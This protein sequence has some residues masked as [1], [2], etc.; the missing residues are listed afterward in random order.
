MKKLLVFL[1]AAVAASATLPAFA[2]TI[3]LS[4]LSG[5]VV[6]RNGDVLTGELTSDNRIY[7]ADGA[8][9]T[10]SNAIV[11]NKAYLGIV[12]AGIRC[13][14]DA[15]IVL[16]GCNAVGGIRKNPGIFVPTNKT[17]TIT[18]SGSLTACGYG[19]GAGIGGGPGNDCGNIIIKGGVINAIGGEMAA[20]I[21]GA[22]SC[23]CGNITIIGGTVA[24]SGAANA[25]GIGAGISG[26]CG[27][28]TISGGTVTA[29]G[30]KMAAG[31]GS[32]SDVD[33]SCGDININGG[34]VVA[35]CGRDCTNPIGAGYYASCGSVTVADGL[36]ESRGSRT[37]VVT[38]YGTVD[39]SMCPVKDRDDVTFC[40]GI[41]LTGTLAVNGKVSIADGAT[42]TLRD[43][44]INGEDSD[45]SGWAGIACEGDATIILEGSNSVRGFGSGFPGIYVPTN[46]TLTIKGDGALTASSYGAAGIGYG[47]FN[48][49]GSICIDGGTIV[50]T[51]GRFYPGIGGRTS[52]CGT[53]AIGSGVTRVVATAGN[54]SQFP[55]AGGGADPNVGVT[56]ADGLLD[57]TDGQTRTIVSGRLDGLTED[58]TLADGMVAT[59]TLHGNR[60]VSIADGATVTLRNVM[61]VGGDYP[62]CRWAG[63]TCEGDATIVIEG[64]S[65]V[66]AFYQDY[67][68][69]S[70]P[71][72][73]TLTIKGAG[74]LTAVGGGRGAGIGGGYGMDCGDIDIWSGSI[75]ALG[76]QYA[77]GI[78][79]GGYGSCGS[80]VARMT[81][82]S[83]MA[84]CG[85]DCSN[86]IGCGA[87]GTGGSVTVEFPLS[88]AS[89]ATTR[90]ISSRIVDLSALT[91]DKRVFDGFYIFG[92][93]A[94][95]HKVSIAD[96]ATVTLVGVE[97]NGV[98]D[99]GCQWAGITCEGDATIIL[100]GP[101]TVK[102]FHRNYPGIYVP[103]GKT[104][105]I[106]GEGVLNASSNG[107]GAGIGGGFYISC[108]NIT[109]DG[110]TVNAAG[111]GY[112]AGI[113]GGSNGGCGTVSIGSGA[114]CV[115]AKCGPSCGNPLGAGASGT[116]GSVRIDHGMSDSTAGDTRT[117]RSGD[118]SILSWYATF[119]DGTVLTGTLDAGY[120]V[121]IAAGATVTLSNA[122]ING[123]N[124]G[125]RQW[126]GITCE[127]DAT[128]VLQGKNTITGFFE[129]YPGI[130]VPSG[131]TL[132]IRGDGVLNASGNGFGAGI[133]GGRGIE[134]GNIVIED[135]RI[136]ATGGAGAAG[137]GGGMG[138]GCGDVS[139]APD[140]SRVVAT[141]GDGCQNPIGAGEGGTCDSVDVSP[142]MLRDETIGSTR[143]LEGGRIIYLDR[144]TRDVA[145]GKN[146]IVKDGRILTG[147]LHG[148]YKISIWEGATV[149]LRDAIIERLGGDELAWAGITCRGNATIVLEGDNYVAGFGEDYPGIYVPPRKTLTIRGDGSL[150]ATT[151]EDGYGAGI[152]AST[153]DRCGNI[154]IEGGT[155]TAKGGYFA[156]GIGGT[157]Q[158]CGI[159][160]INGGNITATGGEGAAGIGGGLGGVCRGVN[161]GS[162]IDRVVATAGYALLESSPNPNPSP[163]GTGAGEMALCGG[164]KLAFGL[165]REDSTDDQERST[166]TIEPSNVDLSQLSGTG[167][168]ILNDGDIATGKLA[169]G[170]KVCIAAG[171]TVMLS[172]VDINFE[173]NEGSDT[174][175]A[176]ITCL[177]NA[178]IMIAGEN[179]V[180]GCCSG[181]PG[182]YVPEDA[183]LTVSGDDGLLYAGGCNYGAGIGGGEGSIYAKCGSVVV[184]GGNVM[185]VG[186][187]LA[188]GL[189]SGHNA[190]CGDITISGGFVS[191]TGGTGGAGIGTGENGQCGAITISGRMI[192]AEGGQGA[193][194]IGSGHG[195]TCGAISI[196]AD[197]TYVIAASGKDCTN[198]IGAGLNGSCA[199]VTVAK[200]LKDELSEDRDVRMISPKEPSA[201]YSSWADVNG[202][203]G[204][205]D[206]TDANGIH[207]VFRYA[208]DKPTGV[209]TIIGIEFND[210]GKAVVVTPPLVNGEGFSL[211]ILA[212]DRCDGEGA[213]ATSYPLDPS[214][215]T[216]I[217][218]TVSGS[219]FFR[220]KAQEE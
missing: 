96:G 216:T 158:G 94:G 86:P 116:G 69:I 183:T 162:G 41:A 85:A 174:P 51:G 201:G 194:G 142:D 37:R 211:S 163:I 195:G 102:G 148:D 49:C 167:T 27:D 28:I 21:G 207:N 58:I 164:V 57:S 136:T 176:G 65:Y 169:A 56:V 185:A 209:F 110:G 218:E 133:G 13:Y 78:G 44:T 156:A 109:I 90:C 212:T 100:D 213:A 38:A 118:L 202:I 74:S 14:G 121:S 84:T 89:N 177:G 67:P 190:V 93:L 99:S 160:T 4:T 8:V 12:S 97:I 81:I 46:K 178:V 10:L 196:T 104:L 72:G 52:A 157:G 139:V 125:Y 48:P 73:K 147:Q 59:G 134:C 188:A 68:G 50:A 155:I 159:I 181:Y 210:A 105:R 187:D 32:G 217:D 33:S 40:D 206:A 91:E 61:I 18:G 151:G 145:I 42:V 120:K 193:A 198:P 45:Y 119:A 7:I 31:I 9:V 152:G 26:S 53:V 172:N 199:G 77:A 154:V 171:A 22:M 129:D 98:D 83:I 182:I 130:F 17:L 11:T 29:T 79:G 173:G 63:I 170:Y 127:G 62:E 200:E 113:G 180:R 168:L 144:I 128:I 103:E 189:G 191:T 71:A 122:V 112:A 184:E 219:R 92:A 140:I 165:R 107:F 30:G 124:D 82:T 150:E 60:K 70:V 108:G 55:I 106:V 161:I 47:S 138:A 175:W 66:R 149:T 54:G 1:A 34:M 192:G 141:C 208:F 153:A 203:A 87:G 215:K 43:V 131:K 2:D 115:T 220:L 76:G 117:V 5:G 166:W 135:G 101:N 197:I 75:I 3:D 204:A 126:A 64:E 143:T 35:T 15:T 6:L 23:E 39:L 186:G 146:L 19:Q 16:A 36:F 95:K 25:S 179:L 20:G 137:I 88:D 114:V 214:G 205:W 123:T 80:I 24:A 132:T 111:G